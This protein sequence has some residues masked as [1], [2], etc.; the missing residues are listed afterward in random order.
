M[1]YTWIHAVK[2]RLTIHVDDVLRAK[3]KI[4]LCVYF[5]GSEYVWSI[6]TKLESKYLRQSLIKIMDLSYY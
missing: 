2:Y 3:I 1:W 5:R 6:M 4:K